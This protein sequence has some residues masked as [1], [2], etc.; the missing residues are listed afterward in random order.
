MSLMNK[1]TLLAI[2]FIKVIEKAT[3]RCL[4]QTYYRTNYGTN[5]KSELIRPPLVNGGLLT[6]SSYIVDL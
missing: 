5:K 6:R 4:Q 2:T 1:K 3:T